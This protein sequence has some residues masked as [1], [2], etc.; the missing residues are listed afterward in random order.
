MTVRAVGQNNNTYPVGPTDGVI[1]GDARSVVWDPCTFQFVPLA[2]RIDARADAWNQDPVNV[3]L[4]AQSYQLQIWG[5]GTGPYHIPEPG[6]L[7]PNTALR[8]ALYTPLTYTPISSG[9]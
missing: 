3:P 5:D 4:A 8:F 1:P 2:Y 9:E 6:R 7:H